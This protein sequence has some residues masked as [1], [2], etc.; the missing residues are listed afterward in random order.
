MGGRPHKSEGELAAPY[1]ST[2]IREPNTL[3]T[4]CFDAEVSDA[5]QMPTGFGMRVFEGELTSR[6]NWKRLK[7]EKSGSDPFL[8]LRTRTKTP[9]RRRVPHR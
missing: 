7:N 8:G 2:D 1:S 3:N 5:R 4:A 6:V 9:T